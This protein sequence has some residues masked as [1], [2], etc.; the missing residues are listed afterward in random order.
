MNHLL[1]QESIGFQ[2]YSAKDPQL[3]R[4]KDFE[5]L[6]PQVRLIWLAAPPINLVRLFLGSARAMAWR[7][8]EHCLL[9]DRHTISSA[10]P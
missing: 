5:Q 6:E 1:S 8:T 3:K 10:T 2:A 7:S 4:A 9:L